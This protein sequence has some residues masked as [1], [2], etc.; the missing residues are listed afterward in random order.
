[1]EDLTGREFG[2]YRVVEALGEGGMAA[3][4]KAYQANMDRYVAVKVL[5]RYFASDPQ[6][7]GRFEQEAKVLAKLQHPHILPVHDFG[8]AEGY[9]YIVMPFVET[10]TLAD[11]LQEQPLPLPQIRSII[12]QVGDA[13]DYAHSAGVVHRDVKPSNVLVDK[14]GNCLLTDFGIA[15]IVEGTTAFTQTGGIIGTPAFMSPEQIRGEKL[16]GRSDIYSLGVVLYEMAAGRP[17]FR[18]E[19]PPAM[20]VKHLNDPLPPPRTHNPDLPE[21]VERVILKSLAKQREDRYATA[22]E[23]VRAL[24][25]AASDAVV[26]ETATDDGSAIPTLVE[27]AT[28]LRSEPAPTLTPPAARWKRHAWLAGGAAVVVAVVLIIYGALLP[29]SGGPGQT[30][31]SETGSAVHSPTAATLIEPAALVPETREASAVPPPATPVDTPTGEPSPPPSPTPGPTHTPALSPTSSPLQP[32]TL[33]QSCGITYTVRAGVPVE[34]RYGG[35]AAAEPEMAEEAA[36]HVTVE[37]LID[38]ESFEG[39]PLSAMATSQLPCGGGELFEGYVVLR[40]A[41]LASLSAGEHEVR[42]TLTADE[43]ISTGFDRDLDGEI[44]FFGPGEL[45]SYQYTLVAQ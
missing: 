15:K 23:M 30:V 16:D 39:V 33:L 18:A 1:M 13:L 22:G 3:V 4:Y 32:V 10:G 5:P 42:L 26:A 6:F 25:A 28:T 44:D 8:E 29:G 35:L 27:R 38:G 2:P 17:P 9:T 34:L 45:G 37:L 36:S 21:G 14:R 31:E 41:R 43:R 40:T 7:V 19:T 12:S 24:Q 11:L 20:L